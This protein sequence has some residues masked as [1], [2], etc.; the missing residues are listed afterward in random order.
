M[1]PKFMPISMQ[2][3][4]HTSVNISG[5]NKMGDHDVDPNIFPI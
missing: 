3:F 2:G 5:K 4:F 1:R